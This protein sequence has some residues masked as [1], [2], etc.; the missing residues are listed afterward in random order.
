M[1]NGR[2]EE[3]LRRCERVR[4][5]AAQT[6]LKGPALVRRVLWPLYVGLPLK[7]VRLV[8][9]VQL[10]FRV[11]L[12]RLHLP[13]FLEE[14]RARHVLSRVSESLQLPLHRSRGRVGG[15]AD[16]E[17]FFCLWLL[18]TPSKVGRCENGPK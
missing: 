16:G 10:N 9:E 12:G 6:E 8:G 7:N 14:P 2:D 18:L 11:L 15:R 1:E 3:H 17:R 13:V 5:R 4:F